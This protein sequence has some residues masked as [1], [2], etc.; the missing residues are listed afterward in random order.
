MIKF[1]LLINK[2]GQICIS[3]HYQHLEQED[4][5]R[6]EKEL[7]GICLKRGNKKSSFLEYHDFILVY[8]CYLDLFFIAG[9]T[10]DENE[11][12]IYEFFHLILETLDKYFP[13][14]SEVDIQFNLDKVH[15]ILDEMIIN[16]NIVETSPARILAPIELL[17][18]AK[19]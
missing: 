12:A 10:K 17:D 8:R 11:M 18:A 2:H 14:L 13:K 19:R 1:L 6:L 16:G 9:I 15:M 5:Q 7:I 3:K 4:R